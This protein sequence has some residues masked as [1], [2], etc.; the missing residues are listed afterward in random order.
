M[1]GQQEQI[2][3]VL[4]QSKNNVKAI[5][6]ALINIDGSEKARNQL[7]QTELDIIYAIHEVKL[8]WNKKEDIKEGV[9]N[10]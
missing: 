5:K 3:K 10:A 2:E 8:M 7:M 9:I 6:E 1:N 4:E